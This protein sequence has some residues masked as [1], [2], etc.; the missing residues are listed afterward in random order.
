MR[1]KAIGIDLGTTNS[2]MAVVREDVP[3]IIPMG[4]NDDQVLRSAVY[5]SNIS[6]QN[7]VSLVKKLSSVGQKSEVQKTLNLTSN[8]TSGVRLLVIHQTTHVSIL[9]FF[10][11]WF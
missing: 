9:L 3:E 4:T 8:V 6:G 11:P 2:V 10:R 1:K 5:F 7:H